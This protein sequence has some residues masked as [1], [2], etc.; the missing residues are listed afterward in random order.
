MAHAIEN[1]RC[2]EL[3]VDAEIKA[4]RIF[5]LLQGFLPRFDSNGLIVC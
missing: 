2:L 5:Q 4:G 1:A 3:F